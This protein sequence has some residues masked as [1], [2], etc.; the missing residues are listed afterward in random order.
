MGIKP[1]IPSGQLAIS[2]QPSGAKGTIWTGTV[3][4]LM[5]SCHTES[6]V[7]SGWPVGH[8]LWEIDMNVQEWLDEIEVHSSRR[9][10]L[11][12]ETGCRNATAIIKW[13]NAAFDLGFAE[14]LNSKFVEV[15]LSSEPE[16]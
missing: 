7:R 16:A 10:R 1:D 14:G 2:Y 4:A 12:D 5:L 6:L 9:E 11:Y 13:L 3:Q 8:L 15:Q